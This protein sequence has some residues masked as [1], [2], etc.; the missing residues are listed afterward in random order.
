MIRT[1]TAVIAVLVFGFS[2]ILAYG[3]FVVMDAVKAMAAMSGG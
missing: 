2:L 3:A 1:S